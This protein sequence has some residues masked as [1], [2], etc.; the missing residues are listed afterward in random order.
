VRGLSIREQEGH[1]IYRYYTEDYLAL[2]LKVVIEYL[3]QEGLTG[4]TRAL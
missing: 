2:A 1:N 4:P 3:V